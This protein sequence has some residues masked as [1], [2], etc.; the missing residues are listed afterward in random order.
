M[1]RFVGEFS[2][3]HINS[4]GIW[5]VN[6]VVFVCLFHDQEKTDGGVVGLS[7]SPVSILEASFSTTD[8]FLSENLNSTP[9]RSQL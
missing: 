1:S 6:S 2:T 8:S 3:P 7:N 4:M 9:G 5:L